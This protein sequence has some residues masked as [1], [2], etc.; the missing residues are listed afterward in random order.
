MEEEMAYKGYDGYKRNKES[1]DNINSTE[2]YGLTGNIEMESSL[3]EPV[4]NVDSLFNLAE[5]LEKSNHDQSFPEITVIPDVLKSV[6]RFVN[7]RKKMKYAHKEFEQKIR[8]LSDGVD[9]QYAIALRKLE[10]E[11]EIRL[12]QIEWNV[13][14]QILSINRYYD[15]ELEKLKAQYNINK[16]EMALYY[17]NIDAQRKEQARRFDKMIQI[18]M[19]E[20]KK[21]IKAVKEAEDVCDYLRIKLYKNT[22]SREEREHYMELLKFRLNG[23]QAVVNI[24][25]QLAAKIK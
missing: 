1:H 2:I 17:E 16:Q 23:T 14:Q 7:E 9:K 3:P 18:A 6:G 5:F 24:I 20:R 4:M 8:F 15:L 12:S 21:A 22:I 11:T 10:S 25:P 19:I 13:K